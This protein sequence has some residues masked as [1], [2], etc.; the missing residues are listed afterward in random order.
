MHTRLMPLVVVA[1]AAVT[2]L[3]AAGSYQAIKEIPIG[4]PGG[5]DYITVDPQGQR[6]Y[7]S[8]QT[9]V[10]VVD[11]KTDKVVGEV[12][13]T[14]GVHGFAVAPDL[15][16]GFSSNGR[17]NSS[18]IVDLKTLKP[19]GKVTT[20]GN[21]DAIIYEPQRKEVYTF[22]G[23]G[24]SA[25]V[26]DAQTGTVV[27]TID[28]KGKPEAPVIDSAAHRVFV[29]LE[30]TAAIAVIDSSTHTLVS[31]WP[32]KGCEEPTGLGYDPKNH[33]LFSACHNKVLTMTDSTSGTVITTVPIGDRVDGAAFDPETG[34]VFTSNGAGTVTIAHL[35]SPNTLTVVQ[36]LNTQPS[37]RTM[38]L[39]PT[40]HN[41]YLPAATMAAGADGRMQATPDTFRVL[42]YGMK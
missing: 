34:F 35:D 5:W 19:I 33:R 15:N 1:F 16:L 7:V 12:T 9:K 23:T 37:A 32:L 27:A 31:T 28:L 4:G 22:N 29:N 20:G 18:T 24:K 14:L 11:L 3:R 2:V 26:F 38:I 41:I 10:V 6:L 42:V 13:D 30:D 25:T 36:T 8:H 39:D 40:T 21:P 17:D